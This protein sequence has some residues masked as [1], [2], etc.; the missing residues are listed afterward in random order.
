MQSIR[1]DPNLAALQASSGLAGHVIDVI[2]LTSDAGLLATLRDASASEHALWHAPSA[3]A[4][5]DLLVGGRCNLLIADLDALHGDAATLLQRL[6]AQFPELVLMATGRRTA[7]STVISLLGS[8]DIYRF[9]H[10]P[11]S[12]ARAQ[13]F[14]AA[15]SRRYT[16]ARSMEPIALTTIKTLS[17]R[18]GLPR[19]AAVLSAALIA[20]LASIAWQ[21][22]DSALPDTP[23]LG[24][25]ASSIAEQ[26]A[27]LL[28]R[29]QMALA[30]GRLSDP[31]GDNALGYFRDVLALQPHQPDALAGIERVVAVMEVRL[32][33]A[34]RAR[35]APRAA[36]AF[37]ALQRAQPRH[38]NLD[39]LQAQLLALSRSIRPPIA[40]AAP[41]DR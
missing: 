12:P 40:P 31:Q 16:Q 18:A 8:G 27:D 38:P 20:L 39:A 22:R 11:V 30:T 3:E 24:M 6:C 26:V 10:K 32:V 5:V 23:P 4:A 19:L 36:A 14:L 9:L 2:V 13:L 28:G 17:S 7:E 41:P 15:A 1:H 25:G 21:T 33:E 35:D 29:A 34:I 37:M